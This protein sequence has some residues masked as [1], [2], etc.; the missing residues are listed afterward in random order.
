MKAIFL[1]SRGLPRSGFV[2]H[3][4]HPIQPKEAVLGIAWRKSQKN[5]L[6]MDKNLVEAKNRIL[7]AKKNNA[8]YLDLSF[9]Q[10]SQV[11]SEIGELN[12]LLELNLSYN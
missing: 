5:T 2:Q 1:Y 6:G 11:P 9:L 7:A 10:L 3:Q 12:Q 4:L 8:L